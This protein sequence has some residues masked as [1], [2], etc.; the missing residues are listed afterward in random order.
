MGQRHHSAPPEWHGA[1][2]SNDITL[3]D[4][5][6]SITAKRPHRI[7]SFEAQQS[8]PIRAAL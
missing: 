1:S 7:L 2:R 4:L 6:L 3:N 5:R 8:L